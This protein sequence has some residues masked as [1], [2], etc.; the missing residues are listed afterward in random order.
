MD[1]NSHDLT[2][3]GPYCKEDPHGI[4]YPQPMSMDEPAPPSFLDQSVAAAYYPPSLLSPVG[5]DGTAAKIGVQGI[6]QTTAG[7][8]N[9]DHY[10]PQPPI[11]PNSQGRG[12]SSSSTIHQDPAEI[13]FNGLTRQYLRFFLPGGG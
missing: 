6:L 10:H 12:T 11:N 7:V 4:Y 3:L 8:S 1:P 2:P 9:Q 13:F 5:M